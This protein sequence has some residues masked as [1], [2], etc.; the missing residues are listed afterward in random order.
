MAQVLETQAKVAEYRGWW[1]QFWIQYS[2]KLG[3]AKVRVLR[4][5][6]LVRVDVAHNITVF[7]YFQHLH[8]EDNL[9]FG[10]CDHRS[11]LRLQAWSVFG[12]DPGIEGTGPLGAQLK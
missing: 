8:L 11:G 6:I 12:H 5:R 1:F 4:L 2:S 3:I 10:H 7:Q 9:Q